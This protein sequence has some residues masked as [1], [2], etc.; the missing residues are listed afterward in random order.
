[1]RFYNVKKAERYGWTAV[2]AP[3]DVQAAKN[4]CEYHKSN[5]RY[6]RHYTNTRWWFMYA[7]DALLFKLAC[8]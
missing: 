8:V 5:G 6:Y 3:K 1:M 4:W 7:E 2:K